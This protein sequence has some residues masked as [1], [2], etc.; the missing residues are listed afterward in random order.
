MYLKNII[1]ILSQLIFN[2]KKNGFNLCRKYLYQV[3]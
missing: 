1:F 3:Q 2:A